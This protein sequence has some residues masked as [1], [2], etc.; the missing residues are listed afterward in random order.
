MYVMY[1][2]IFTLFHVCFFH[3]AT[4][5]IFLFRDIRK[6]FT[7]GNP[8]AFLCVYVGR[9]SKEK[10][11]EVMVEAVRSID[12]AYL[13]IIGDGPSAKTYAAMHGKEN[14]IYCKPRFL[15]HDEL[16]Q[17]YASSDVHVSASEFETLGNTVL[18]AFGCQV[19]VVVPRTQVKSV[20][21]AQKSSRVA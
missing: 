7:F 14:R 1:F 21:T 3:I 20:L 18:E 17:V 10:R 19:P 11:M 8:D 16:A 15:T 5:F 2:S 13:A 6:E 12:N 4:H 9:I